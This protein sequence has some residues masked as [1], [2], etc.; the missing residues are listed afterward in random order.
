MW[1]DSVNGDMHGGAHGQQRGWVPG[2]GGPLN[3]L[4]H[5]MGQAKWVYLGND[6]PLSRAQRCASCVE[7]NP[8]HIKWGSQAPWPLGMVESGSRA[9]RAAWSKA[10]WE[11]GHWDPGLWVLGVWTVLSPRTVCRAWEWRW[12]RRPESPRVSDSC[13]FMSVKDR[14][15]L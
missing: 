13:P 15:V 12:G 5:Y 2:G 1:C 11:S 9:R 8:L 7:R 6:G 10:R 14:Q 3:L 4:L